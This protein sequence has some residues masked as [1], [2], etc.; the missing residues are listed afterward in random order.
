MHAVSR[1]RLVGVAAAFCLGSLWST[2]SVARGQDLN[3][4]SFLAGDGALALAGAYTAVAD[5]PSATFY[6]P[7]AIP[8]AE[9]GSVSGSLS[10]PILNEYD[11]DDGFPAAGGPTN[12]SFE[13]S[14]PIPFFLGATTAAGPKLDGQA[15]H[16]L[17]VTTL[18]PSRLT[19][20]FFSEQFGS[21]S[22]S[23]L[24]VR[25][26]DSARWFGVA[27]GYRVNKSFGIGASLFLARR[28][29][30]YEEAETTS[31]G[32]ASGTPT[33]LLSVSARA[34]LEAW[35]GV[36]RIGALYRVSSRVQLGA[37]FQMPSLVLASSAT[38]ASL[39]ANRSDTDGRVTSQSRET[40][41]EAPIPWQLRVGGV[42]RGSGFAIS[43]DVALHGP[44][45]SSGDPVRF[46]GLETDEAPPTRYLAGQYSSVTVVN[47]ALG[48]A[49]RA[50]ESVPIRA[51]FF[52][53]F[54]GAPAPLG[55]T[56]RY[57]PDSVDAY[58]L[59]ASIGF[60]G[61]E[62]DFS[63]GVLAMLGEGKGL[64][65]TS[66]EPTSYVQTDV[67]LRS[68]Q[69]FFTGVG[70]TAVRLAEALADEV[71]PDT[72]EASDNTP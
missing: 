43:A 58:G 66:I 23:S 24:L 49:I 51:G 33:E 3:Y 17:G 47:A 36:M 11:V 30:T 35:L 25:N 32:V 59:S 63:V 4:Q 52:T 48:I 61:E 15:R 67:R 28:A 69:L 21:T 7:G 22:A 1:G 34:D 27:Y 29:V 54:S 26:E 70:G 38:V 31:L 72:P 5:G 46:L 12:L 41:P 18:V 56:D 50:S 68:V 65:A 10:L 53:N 71:L 55:S 39:R 16:G 42:Y 6:N 20:R 2:G 14:T 40:S 13:A 62:Y 9:A 64:R 57:T 60:Q 45:G 44:L 19:R 37:M 8:F